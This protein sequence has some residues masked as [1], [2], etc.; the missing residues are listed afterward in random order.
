M[1]VISSVVSL[2]AMEGPQSG[3]RAEQSKLRKAERLAHLLAVLCVGGWSSAIAADDTS[4]RVPRPDRAAKDLDKMIEDLI[5]VGPCPPYR[6][7]DGSP[8]CLTAS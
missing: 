1:T 6:W 7:D 3:C 8:R 5:A 4:T 2:G